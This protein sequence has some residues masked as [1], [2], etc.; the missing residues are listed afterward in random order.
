MQAGN[1]E[2]YLI[3]KPTRGSMTQW[4]I[5]VGTLISVLDFQFG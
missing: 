4:L 1:G 5:S 3:I 2:D